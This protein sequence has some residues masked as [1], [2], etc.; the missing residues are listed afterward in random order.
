LIGI[1]GAGKTAAADRFLQVLPGALPPHPDVP[2]RTD[3]SQPARLFVFSF[4]AAPNPDSFF[5]DLNGFLLESSLQA[6]PGQAEAC[7]PTSYQQTL[8]TLQA[9]GPCLL[10]LDGLEKVQDD[11]ARGGIFGELHDGRL[12]S[13]PTTR[14]NRH[15]QTKPRSKK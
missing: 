5:A 15:S 7:T 1:G 3:L 2:K 6:V 9:A 12:A 14:S 13:S 10:I 8:L 4:Y 11:G